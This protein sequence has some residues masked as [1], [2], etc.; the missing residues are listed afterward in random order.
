MPTQ[1][2]SIRE[3]PIPKY[4]TPKQ[5]EKILSRYLSAPMVEHIMFE[6]CRVLDGRSLSDGAWIDGLPP[7][8]EPESLDELRAH[9]LQAGKRLRELREQKGVADGESTNQTGSP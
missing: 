2:Q 7:I 6:I 1:N 9:F 3:R 8:G 5:L 4:P